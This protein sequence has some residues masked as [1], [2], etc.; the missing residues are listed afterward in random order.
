MQYFFIFYTIYPS[1][2]ILLISIILNILLKNFICGIIK[3]IN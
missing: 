1:F 3:I 2:T